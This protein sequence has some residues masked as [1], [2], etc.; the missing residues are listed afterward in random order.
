MDMHTCES[1]IPL[2]RLNRVRRGRSTIH[3]IVAAAYILCDN[4]LEYQRAPQRVS[5]MN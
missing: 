3:N 5:D 1:L 2:R 4:N